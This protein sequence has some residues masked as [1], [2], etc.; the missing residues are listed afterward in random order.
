MNGRIECVFD[1]GRRKAAK[2]KSTKKAVSS[3][4]CFKCSKMTPDKNASVAGNTRDSVCST[5]T[6][7][8]S[9]FVH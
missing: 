1:A 8:R 6:T 3:S 9:V 4:Y 2:R 7:K 5:C